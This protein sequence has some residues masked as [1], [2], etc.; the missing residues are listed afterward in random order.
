MICL[1]VHTSSRLT[2]KGYG[3]QQEN[4]CEIKD[5][6]WEEGE[7]EERVEGDGVSLLGEETADLRLS[8]RGLLRCSSTLGAC[9]WHIDLLH[10][11]EWS[12]L[13]FFLLLNFFFTDLHL[14]HLTTGHHLSVVVRE[15]DIFLHEFLRG[16]R[17]GRGGGRLMLAG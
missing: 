17:G 8:D 11:F 1:N 6:G 3:I 15:G 2:M 5:H 7:E 13:L 9:R 10:R 16:T 4:V 12:S 14:N